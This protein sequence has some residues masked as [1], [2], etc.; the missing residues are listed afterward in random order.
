MLDPTALAGSDDA[1]VMAPEALAKLAAE[2]GEGSPVLR[3]LLEEL[4][5]GCAVAKST[6]N[7]LSYQGLMLKRA[8][9]ALET[10]AYYSGGGSA[11][12]PA[13]SQATAQKPKA[14]TAAAATKAVTKEA[15]T[16]GSTLPL[17]WQLPSARVPSS[18]SA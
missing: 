13:A 14:A 5:E 16:A 7:K 15:A 4:L 1:R 10:A 2:H 12:T 8:L 11:A 18:T 3:R 6:A 9:N 17:L